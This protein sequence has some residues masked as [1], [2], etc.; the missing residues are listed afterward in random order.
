MNESVHNNVS[1]EEEQVN[2]KALIFKYLRYWPWFILSLFMALSLAFLYNR[3]TTNI[4][5]TSA[6]IK[7]LKDQNKGMDLSGLEGAGSLFNMREVNLENEIEILKSR[8]LLDS[9]VKNL[10]LNTLYYKEGDITT[11]EVWK[12]GIPFE[13]KW[14]KIDSSLTKDFPMFSVK[15]TSATQFKISENSTEIS[16]KGKL[17]EIIDFIG[18]RFRLVLNPN[19]HQE[20]YKNLKGSHYLFV[21]TST[22][23]AVDALTAKLEINQ[24]GKQSEILNIAYKGANKRKNEAILDTLILHFN[25]D[26]MRDKQKIS[27]RTEEFVQERLKSLAKELDTVETG[28]V[29]FKEGNRVVT[30]ESTAQQLFGKEAE[31]ERKR[32]EVQTQKELAMAFRDEL[33]NGSDYQLLPSNLGL[34]SKS[35]NDLT[36]KYNQAVLALNDL[37]TSATAEN[38]LVKNLKGKLHNLKGNILKSVN[39][40]VHSLDLSLQRFKGREG[41]TSGRLQQ[42]PA[43]QK[44]IRAIT[45]QQEIKEKLYLFLLQK[46]EEAGLQYATTSP[47]IK[48]VDY[49]YSNPMPIAPKKKIIYLAAFVLG[50]LIP[51]G[52][53]YLKFLFHTKINSK[54]DI[55]KILPN[56]PILAEIPEIAKKSHRLIQHNDRSILAESFRIL[57]TNVNFLKAKNPNKTEAEVVFVTSTTKGEGKTFVAINIANSL[58]S[59]GKKTLFIGADLRNPQTHNYYALDKNYVGVTAF[60]SDPSLKMRDITHH[61]IG[62]FD[63]LD[64]IISG[65]IPPNPAELLMGDRFEELIKEARKEY[66]YVIVDTAPTILVT[67]TLL[68]SHLADLTL[69]MVR[70]DYTESRVLGHVKE[71]YKDKKLKRMGLVFNGVN[72][73]SGYGYS[74]SYNYGYGYGYSESTP[75]AWWQFWKKR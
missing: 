21:R 37:S 70:N 30:I 6:E 32:F 16:K 59:T 48:V 60:I 15:F 68:I 1:Q 47:T 64:V 22:Q 72:R 65:E 5:Q 3:Y 33:L 57:R 51:F 13:V 10:N 14:E 49:A 39:G 66:D 17:N 74:Y 46:R 20:A 36:A 23:K 38:P 34:E 55:E 2:I 12:N 35:V 50:L 45:R 7:V 54:E 19:F 29:N 42:I 25:L 24:V 69:Y 28:L 44:R 62:H 73:K 52:F 71:M 41:E 58:A 75:K 53:F 9:V 40:Y 18:Y 67:D 63:N 61:D 31:S 26:G 27:K 4:Y 8:K 43:T 11:N 56:I